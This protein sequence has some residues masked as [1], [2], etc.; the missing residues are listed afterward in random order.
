MSTTVTFGYTGRA[1]GRWVVP[2]I[3]GTTV[4]VAVKG[5]GGGFTGDGA[6]GQVRGQV[7][8]SAG[9]VLYINVGGTTS[10]SSGGFNGGGDGGINTGNAAR[11]GYGGGGGSDIRK[12]GTALAN[13][14]AVA[15]GGGGTGRS[16]TTG[17]RGAGGKGGAAT[18]QAGHNS[19]GVASLGG[20]GGTQSAG[21]A[22]GTSAN[23]G[24]P[25]VAGALGVAGHGGNGALTTTD[26]GGGGG[27]GYYGGGGGAASASNYASPGGGG[28]SNYIGG[29]TGGA[30]TQGTGSPARAHGSIAITYNV[31]AGPPTLYPPNPLMDGGVFAGFPTAFEWAL[32]D[33]DAP[34]TI[35][36]SDFRYRVAGTSTWTTVH[37]VIGAGG[38]FGGVEFAAGTFAPGDYEA[39]ARTTGSDGTTS[40]YT[41]S[42]LFTVE[43]PAAAAYPYV[44]VPDQ[45]PQD[46]STVDRDDM[47]LRT[48]DK[49]NRLARMISSWMG[50][51]PD[52]PARSADVGFDMYLNNDSTITANTPVPFDVTLGSY[53][54]V[55]QLNPL[56]ADG[57]WT[58]T[59]P[60]RYIIGFTVRNAGAQ[61]AHIVRLI[62]LPTVYGVPCQQVEAAGGSCG[63][64]DAIVVRLVGGEQISVQPSATVVYGGWGYTDPAG[65]VA[66]AT[67][68]YAHRIGY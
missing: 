57:I 18:G 58:V 23:G 65:N 35:V 59:H 28:G 40:A 66:A 2:A 14:V 62:G 20:G 48:T 11:N 60:G 31:A 68:F 43:T 12:G 30:S 6:G 44:D 5:A 22:G 33:P 21:G 19:V 1:N 42:L 10:G 26:C 61:P 47:A 38:T 25:G 17:T 49:I 34:D 39:Q 7:A 67:R 8:V 15:G 24:Q 32:N 36:S 56:G 37:T 55:Y 64:V 16:G 53:G 41:S 13:R 63:S 3:S 29:L 52:D 9:D 50:T 4:T 45:W 46:G 54:A 27:G 51:D